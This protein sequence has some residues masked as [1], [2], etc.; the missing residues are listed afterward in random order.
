MTRETFFVYVEQMFIP[1]VLQKRIEIGVGPTEPAC[2]LLD[3]HVSR[4]YYDS[5]KLLADNHIHACIFPADTGPVLDP[6]DAGINGCLKQKLHSFKAKRGLE[7][8]TDL[9]E[10]RRLL[11]S[12]LEEAEA[13]TCTRP[14][15]QRVF[16]KTG[17]HPWDATPLLAGPAGS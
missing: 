16:A 6:L 10:R 7:A 2:F 17:H 9:P 15:I 12:I 1:A 5:I 14:R 11:L 3:G 4:D 8:V 13:E